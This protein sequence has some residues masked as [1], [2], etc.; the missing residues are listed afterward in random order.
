MGCLR[1]KANAC[2]YKESD[3]WLAEK[4]INRINDEMKTVT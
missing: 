2:N 1:I 3:R 4:I